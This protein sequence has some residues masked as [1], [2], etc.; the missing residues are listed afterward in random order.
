MRADGSVASP[1]RGAG[2]AVDVHGDVNISNDVRPLG[3]GVRSFSMCVSFE[4]NVVLVDDPR[5]GEDCYRVEHRGGGAFR[6]TSRC[7]RLPAELR[8]GWQADT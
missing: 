5:R 7:A 1:R 3:A 8:Q 2:P 4:T 6:W